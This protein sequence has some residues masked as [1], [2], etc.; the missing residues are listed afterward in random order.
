M[1]NARPRIPYSELPAALI[2]MVPEPDLIRACANPEAGTV[3]VW[4]EPTSLR[5]R[6][7]SAVE[8]RFLTRAE[9]ERA[10]PPEREFSIPDRR[11]HVVH[12]ASLLPD[13]DV[14]YERYIVYDERRERLITECGQKFFAPVYQDPEVVVTDAVRQATFPER[15]RHEWSHSERVGHWV[16][17]L[18]RARR[19]AGE[20]G[21]DEESAFGPDAWRYMREVDP[22]IE[23]LLPEIIDELARLWMTDPER[24][25]EEFRRRSGI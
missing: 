13:S 22:D 14:R 10:L 9:R 8:G 20:N 21:N 12:Q 5:E 19:W 1:K 11:V 7:F 23:D 25:L 3:V 15:Y 24:M 18:H 16:S 6:E 4:M 17:W 2:Q